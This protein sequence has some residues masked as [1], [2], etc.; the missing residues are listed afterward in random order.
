MNLQVERSKQIVE[1]LLT[2]RID[3]ALLSS[4]INI[5]NDKFTRVTICCEKLVVIVPPTHHLAYSHYCTLDDIKHETFI[6]KDTST[7]LMR[8]ITQ[9]LNNPD[10]VLNTN[11]NMSNQTSIKHAVANGMGISIV[12]EHLIK[13][14]VKEGCLYQLEITDYPLS[15]DIQLIYQSTLPLKPSA[16]LLIDYIKNHYTL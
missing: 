12:S 11:I 13:N 1:L 14:D 3:L 2:Q 15:R 9:S 4:Y 16:T 8:H 5:P 6:F 7:A 10:L